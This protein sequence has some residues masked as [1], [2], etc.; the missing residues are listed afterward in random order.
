MPAIK[1]P[2]ISKGISRKQVL[3][4]FEKDCKHMKSSSKLRLHP[5]QVPFVINIMQTYLVP[6]IFMIARTFSPFCDHDYKHIWYLPFNYYNHMCCPMTRKKVLPEISDFRFFTIRG[7]RIL[8]VIKIGGFFE[9][10]SDTFLTD[11]S[12]SHIKIT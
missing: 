12:K 5:Y 8:L 7:L 9:V 1:V 11:M 4:S 10:M 6:I 3:Q 2:M